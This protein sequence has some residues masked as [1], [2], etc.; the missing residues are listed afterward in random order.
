MTKDKHKTGYGN[1]YLSWSSASRVDCTDFLD[2]HL[3]SVPIV[4]LSWQALCMQSADEYK[5][6][7]IIWLN[8]WD[9]YFLSL[10]IFRLLSSYSLLSSQRFGRCI[11]RSSSGVSCRTREPKQKFEPKPLFNPLEWHMVQRI[12]AFGWEV[13]LSKIIWRLQV[14][15]QQQMNNKEYLDL[16][17]VPDYG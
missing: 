17:L 16:T 13:L 5:S 1:D 4:P 11:L 12:W 8:F 2:T 15:S 9:W 6:L 10:R 14:Q 7:L 3:P